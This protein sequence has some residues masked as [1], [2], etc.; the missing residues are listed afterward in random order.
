MDSH[1]ILFWFILDP[2]TFGLG[3]IGA[4]IIFRELS[5]L[6][7]FPSMT[8]MLKLFRNHWL[9]FL[10]IAIAVGYF[11]YRLVSVLQFAGGTSQ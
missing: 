3:S 5:D 7:H 6:D 11:C 1:T 8:E 10:F 9:A 2:I 4:Y